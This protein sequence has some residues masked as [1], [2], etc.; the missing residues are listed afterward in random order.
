[1]PCRLSLSRNNN[2]RIVFDSQ[3]QY[4]RLLNFFAIDKGNI[5]LIDPEVR[6]FIFKRKFFDYYFINFCIERT[7][8]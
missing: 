6:V 3:E 5:R 2:I 1:M 8:L 7:D 4:N